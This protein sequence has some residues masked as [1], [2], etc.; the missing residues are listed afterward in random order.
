MYPEH[1]DAQ[2]VLFWLTKIVDEYKPYE[3]IF[4][5]IQDTC[6]SNDGY[7]ADHFIEEREHPRRIISRLISRIRLLQINKIEGFRS[8]IKFKRHHETD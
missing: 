4:S 2:S 3:D 7:C 8:S 1:I 5:F 6:P